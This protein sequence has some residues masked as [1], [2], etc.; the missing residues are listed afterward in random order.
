[1]TGFVSIVIVMI[2]STKQAGVGVAN[3]L[4]VGIVIGVT[5]KKTGFAATYFLTM[6]IVEDTDG[7]IRIMLGSPWTTKGGVE[8]GLVNVK[9]GSTCR[10]FYASLSIPAKLHKGKQPLFFVFESE[11]EGQSICEFYD[12]LMLARP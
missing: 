3:L 2:V 10:E 1:M 9:A 5:T 4:A 7:R 6:L 11:T 12:F 8:I